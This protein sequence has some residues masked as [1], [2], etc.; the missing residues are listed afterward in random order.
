[1]EGS[2]FEDVKKTFKSALRKSGKKISASMIRHTFASHL[3]MAGI[4]ILTVKELLGNKTLAMILRYAHLAPSHKV[5][6][7]EIL[8]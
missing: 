7:L 8:D 5:N 4:E 3:L 2:R 1:M 6:A